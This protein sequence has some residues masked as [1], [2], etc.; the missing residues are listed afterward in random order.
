VATASSLVLG[1]LGYAAPEQMGSLPEGGLVDSRADVFSLSVVAF[2]MLTGELPWRKDS[3]QSYV[4]DLLMRREDEVLERVS[5][6]APGSWHGLLSRGLARDRAR[7]TQDMETLAE[8]MTAAALVPREEKPAARLRLRP[9]SPPGKRR[10]WLAGGLIVAAMAVALWFRPDTATRTPSPGLGPVARPTGASP[11]TPPPG[12]G[13]PA[14]VPSATPDPSG[15]QAVER[16][17][18]QG[19]ASTLVEPPTPVSPTLG[20]LIVQSSP[21]AEV[22]LDGEPRGRTPAVLGSLAPRKHELV[23][24]SDDGRQLSEVIEVEAGQTVRRDYEFPAFGSL[25]VVSPNWVEVRIDDGPPQETPVR[26]L[27]LA[28]GRHR[29]RASRPGY[30]TQV[31][32][33]EIEAG[34]DRQL[35]IELEKSP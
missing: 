35:V 11:R 17:Q 25:S 23:L 20:R 5:S 14:T 12:T 22:R 4:H 30:E 3:F 18:T 16:A 29:V 21:A 13:D 8:E 10:M 34:Q 1:K 15:S 9:P 32:E 6:R 2:E 33:V 24:T 31:L 19:P 28:A 27:R 7:R 26:F